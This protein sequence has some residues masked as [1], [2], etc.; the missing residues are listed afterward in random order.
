MKTVVLSKLSRVNPLSARFF[1]LAVAVSV[2]MGLVVTPPARAGHGAP[3][4]APLAFDETH[5]VIRPSQ[6]QEITGE[7]SLAANPRG[8]VFAWFTVNGMDAYIAGWSGDDWHVN[9]RKEGDYYYR[10]PDLDGRYEEFEESFH[11][12]GSINATAD[13]GW[14]APAYQSGYYWWIDYL[15]PPWSS[16]RPER[17]EGPPVQAGGLAW[18]ALTIETRDT[19][20]PVAVSVGLWG[21]VDCTGL[22]ASLA[23]E[24]LTY[25]VV[26]NQSHWTGGFSLI[27]RRIGLETETTALDT[28]TSPFQATSTA[29][30]AH[31]KVHVVYQ[32]HGEQTNELVHAT[33]ETGRWSFTVV[34]ERPATNRLTDVTIAADGDRLHIAAVY[35]ATPDEPGRPAIYAVREGGEGRVEPIAD[36]AAIGRYM[37]LAL[38][39]DGRAWV[40][41]YD[42]RN[43][44]LMVA[45]RLAD[46]WFTRKLD[47]SENV[48]RASALVFDEAGDLHVAYTRGRSLWHGVIYAEN[49]PYRAFRGRWLSVD[50]RPHP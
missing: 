9:K 26:F 47:D 35:Q 10:E 11:A 49:L 22:G 23:I 27:Y 37:S 28:A 39:A 38:D 16:K 2:A 43:Q 46:D 41:Y 48:G 50:F 7:I 42:R 34:D 32:R 24:N 40:T 12:S 19:L 17:K 21:G 31:G 14:A 44:A 29:V 1:L 8:D 5:L 30:G 45:T 3:I 15:Y 4:V 18:S 20:I 36:G 25:H 33:D 13:G 6:R